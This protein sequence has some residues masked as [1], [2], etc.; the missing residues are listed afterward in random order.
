MSDIV[1]QNEIPILLGTCIS[2]VRQG[3]ASAACNTGHCLSLAGGS[4]QLLHVQIVL[5]GLVSVPDFHCGRS[6]L[7]ETRLEWG[8]F[9]ATLIQGSSSQARPFLPPS[10]RVLGF[11]T[12]IVVIPEYLSIIP[13]LNDTV[14]YSPDIDI[15]FNC[16]APTTLKHILRPALI[17]PTLQLLFFFFTDRSPL[18]PF[19]NVSQFMRSF[20]C[21][22]RMQPDGEPH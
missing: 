3:T 15:F 2:Q 9:N 4:S 16:C 20:N 18:R 12:Y 10:S 14:L 6:S 17:P 13:S 22:P 11:N 8:P 1:H 7:R 19:L 5:R 21:M